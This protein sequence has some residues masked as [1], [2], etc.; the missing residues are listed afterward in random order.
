[1]LRVVQVVRDFLTECLAPILVQVTIFVGDH[2]ESHVLRVVQ[3]VGDSLTECLAPIL[4]QDGSW[5]GSSFA[6]LMPAYR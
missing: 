2:G 5:Y 6:V 1:M 3:V 4:V